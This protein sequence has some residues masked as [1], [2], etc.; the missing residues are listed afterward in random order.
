MREASRFRRQG[1]KQA[2][3]VLFHSAR[4]RE[5]GR[6]MIGPDDLVDLAK[7]AERERRLQQAAEFYQRAIDQLDSAGD[8]MRAAHVARHLAEIELNGGNVEEASLRIAQVLLFYRGRQVPRL[9]MANTLR[10][11]ALIDEKRGFRDEAR[12]FWIEALQM[13]AREGV[14]AGVA[15][16]KRR[17]ARLANA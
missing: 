3:K 10:V 16:A 2:S 6:A 14:D 7:A 11:A 17:L 9:E 1:Q 13:Y 4:G 8:L 12:E 15:E 5:Q